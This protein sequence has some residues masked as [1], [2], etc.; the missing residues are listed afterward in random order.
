MVYAFTSA[1]NNNGSAFAGLTGNTDWYNTTLGLSMLIG[2]FVL[3]VPVLA[4]AGSLAR[5]QQVPASAGTFPTG[6]PLFAGLL[7]GVVVDRR[8]PHLLPRPG[9]RP[10]RRAPEHLGDD[11]VTAVQ[12]VD[13]PEHAAEG[14]S[15]KK[16][17]KGLFDPAILRRASIDSFKKLDPRLMAKNPV[18]FVV[19]VGS[20]LTTILFFRDLGKDTASQNWFAGLV[21]A[22]ALVHRAVRQLRRGHGRGAGQGPGRHPAQGPG[23]HD[24]Q[25]AHGPTARSRRCRA[26]SSRSATSASSWPAS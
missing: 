3:M 1:G 20:V 15:L 26:R 17:S 8:R 4:I 12:H 25:R 10:H 18:M 7:V 24:R 22:V 9:P 5:K 23:R 16:E 13:Q 19:E 2:R 6:T 14:P 21:A 11:D